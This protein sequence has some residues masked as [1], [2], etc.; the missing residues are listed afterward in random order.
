MHPHEFVSRVFACAD[1]K[2][3]VYSFGGEPDATRCASCE[4][5][6]EMKAEGKMS[7]AAEV[8]LRKLLGCEIPTGEG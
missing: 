3:D 1:C 8:E 6:A 7:P 4:T 5:I 2:S